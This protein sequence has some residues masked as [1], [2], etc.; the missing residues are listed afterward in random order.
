[1]MI[2]IALLGLAVS[3]NAIRVINQDFNDKGWWINDLIKFSKKEYL[4]FISSRDGLPSTQPI[5]MESVKR[6]NPIVYYWSWGCFVESLELEGDD[7]LWAVKADLPGQHWITN[8]ATTM[9]RATSIKRVAA[10]SQIVAW[11]ASVTTTVK[12]IAPN[13]NELGCNRAM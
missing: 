10:V 8:N 13:R 9:P 6:V 12:A 2:F 4:L 3:I 5:H 1:M 7:V 11:S